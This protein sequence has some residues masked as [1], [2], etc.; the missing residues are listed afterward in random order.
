MTASNLYYTRPMNLHRPRQNEQS[1]QT[2]IA[3]A[4]TNSTLHRKVKVTLPKPDWEK[5][6]KDK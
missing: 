1:M 6:G 4:Q 5:D 3:T 2:K